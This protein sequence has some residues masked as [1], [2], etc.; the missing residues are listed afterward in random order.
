M[1]RA[2]GVMRDGQ[3]IVWFFIGSHAEYD[4]LLRR[5]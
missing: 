2:V 3:T 4:Q 5:R 1:Y